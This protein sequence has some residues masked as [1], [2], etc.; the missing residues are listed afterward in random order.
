MIQE[1]YPDWPAP[2]RHPKF[3]DEAVAQALACL[4]LNIALPQTLC[5]TPCE[6]LEIEG[7][8]RRWISRTLFADL[9]V[10]ENP[11]QLPSLLIG[12]AIGM[13]GSVHF[14]IPVQHEIAWRVEPFFECVVRT[15]DAWAVNTDTWEPVQCWRTKITA[16][17]L[18]VPEGTAL[19]P[20]GALTNP[21]LTTARQAQDLCSTSRSGMDRPS[22]ADDCS[23]GKSKAS[24]TIFYGQRASE[25]PVPADRL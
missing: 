17:Y 3:T 12:L 5:A 16:V 8:G 24:A 25:M 9:D 7:K 15:G 21:D 2:R 10:R 14:S 20:F 22:A 19:Q 4:R 11:E 23:S 1:A 18:P 6:G 13:A